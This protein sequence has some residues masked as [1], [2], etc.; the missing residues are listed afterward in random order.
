M[1]TQRSIVR[2]EWGALDMVHREVI[3]LTLTVIDSSSNVL[4]SIRLM[5]YYDT[6]DILT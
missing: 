1:V 2:V 6:V 3:R 5:P 4:F